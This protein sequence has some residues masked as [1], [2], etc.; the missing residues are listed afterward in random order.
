MRKQV[1]GN[2]LVLQAVAG[3]YVVTMGWDITK[4]S[5][6]TGLQRLHR[7]LRREMNY[8]EEAELYWRKLCAALENY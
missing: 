7:N 5:V 2:G 6:R 1:R 8:L 4:E 3:T